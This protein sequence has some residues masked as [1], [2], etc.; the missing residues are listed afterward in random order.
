MNL[1]SNLN[2][3]SLVYFSNN[4]SSPF[5]TPGMHKTSDTISVSAT[6]LDN[7]GASSA[8]ATKQQPLFSSQTPLTGAVPQTG[9]AV[10]NSNSFGGPASQQQQGW[11][12]I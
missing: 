5:Y 9:A 2:L 1:F 8:N 11:F 6:A 10:P 4:A 3:S 7:H 12:K